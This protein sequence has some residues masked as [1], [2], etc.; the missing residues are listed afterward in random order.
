LVRQAGF[1]VVWMAEA[2][3]PKVVRQV[4]IVN[5]IEKWL[6]RPLSKRRQLIFS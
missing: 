3:Y 2:G 1:F 5:L 6:Q 4:W